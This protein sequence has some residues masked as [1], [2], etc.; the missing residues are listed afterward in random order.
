MFSVFKTVLILSAAGSALAAA[1]MLLK[2]LTSRVFSAK[3][4]YY[5]WIAVLIVMVLPLPIKAKQQIEQ[6]KLSVPIPMMAERR[7]SFGEP[8]PADALPKK[9][10]EQKSSVD[11]KSAIAYTWAAGAAAYIILS[12]LSYWRFILRKRRSSE[13]ADI[14][15]SEAAAKIGLKRLPRVRTDGGAP[16]LVGVFR[17]VI[18][19]PKDTEDSMVLMHELIHYKR[20]DLLYKWAAMFINGIHWF[21][22]MAYAVTENINEACEI[23]CDAAVTA[24]MSEDEKKKYMQTILMFISKKEDKYVQKKLYNRN[25]RKQAKTQKTVQGDELK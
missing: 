7:I 21:N 19:L 3:W 9:E 4:Q 25:E 18:Y 17:P 23:S 15:L 10:P 13:A 24:N 1:L 5:I 12:L 2:P 22:P 8:V 14:D 11:W 20:R 6:P 16:M